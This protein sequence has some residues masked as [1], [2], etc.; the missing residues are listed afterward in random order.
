MNIFKWLASLEPF[1]G[2]DITDPMQV[3][4]S[5]APALQ[6]AARRVPRHVREDWIQE[7]MCVV[8]ERSRA[9]AKGYD[10]AQRARGSFFG[11]TLSEAKQ[12]AAYTSAPSAAPRPSRSSYAKR[13]A[14]AQDAIDR[15][16]QTTSLNEEYEDGGLRRNPEAPP[17]NLTAR[18]D[19]LRI[20]STLPPRE[21][22]V[23]TRAYA[24]GEVDRE[25]A[26]DLKMTRQGAAWVRTQALERVRSKL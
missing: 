25:I 12:K 9:L 8:L 21:Q 19:V 20:L 10:Q 4:A 26:K 17:I 22:A 3:L 13:S 23:L 5:Y 11:F 24:Y 14:D 6:I 16:N 15:Y 18:L 7:A 1:Q 2:P